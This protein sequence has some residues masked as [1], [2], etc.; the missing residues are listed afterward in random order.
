[1]KARTFLTKAAFFLV[2][3]AP[4]AVPA[5]CAGQNG[6]GQPGARV[7]CD[8]LVGFNGTVREGSFAPV[9]LSVENPG[10]RTSAEISVTVTWGASR[11]GQPGFTVTR[12][13]ALDEGSTSR[14]PFVVPL[15]RNA[16]ALRA[17]VASQGVEI[18]SVEIDPRSLVEAD[19]IIVGISSDLSL[20][21]V[22]ALGAGEGYSARVVY[23]RVDDL[24][25]SWAGYDGV[26]AVIVHDTYFRQ[27]RSDQ[28]D[29]IEKW[30]V[31]G[32][33]LVFTGGAAALQHEAA[34]FG[35]L[36]PVRVNGLTQRG[37]I[38]V[39][40]GGKAPRRLPGR[41]ELADTRLV[42]GN[43][44]Q[45]D[46][47]L[48]LVVRYSLGRGKV[49][50]LAFDPTSPP[51]STW[52][53]TLALWRSILE[54]DRV[55]VLGA[56]SRPAMEDPWIAAV[57]SAAPAS[58]PPAYAALAF[59][60]AYLV[61]LTPLFLARGIR[62]RAR[63]LLLAV[64]CTAA[65]AAGWLLFNRALFDS[66]LQVMDMARVE[67]RS[68][69]GV[70]FVT[71]KTAFFSASAR[72]V[73]ARLGSADAVVEAAGLRTS[74]NL[75]PVE[76]HIFESPAASGTLVTGIDLDRFFA[77]LIAVQDTV[78]FDV[79]ARIDKNGPSLHVFVHNGTGKPLSGCYI[80]MPKR[81]FSLGD[82]PAGAEIQRS[83][84]DSE[85]VRSDTAGATF[86]WVDKRRAALFEAQE[87]EMHQDGPPRLVGWM[88]S[89]VLPISFAAS[90][91]FDGAPGLALVSVE[92]E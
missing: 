32:G 6:Q 48:P 57:F 72:R 3:C 19:R 87:G 7:L 55:P 80:L 85:G 8:A 37:G 63:L 9:I 22:S 50:F 73:E 10:Q 39:S 33:I 67:A 30:V 24:P 88:D 44:L 49:W 35:R 61:L 77:R 20:D 91:P 27:L 46:G 56:A 86:A 52:D 81:A 64:V 54:T 51:L 68:G 45:T 43:A 41:V 58:F 74:Q 31:S 40:V 5:P 4:L 82:L 13:A 84:T 16:R 62:G 38:S 1:M 79:T 26:D 75:P 89:P 2:F 76:P 59:V 47:T 18:G 60:G 53:G 23:P 69:D 21:A 42:R 70:A 17:A 71:E 29:A 28:V 25:R 14:F 12:E 92:A 15:P 78:P 36:L 34:G 11:A 66:A 83:F 90:H 65:G